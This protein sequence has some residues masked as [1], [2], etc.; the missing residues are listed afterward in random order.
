MKKSMSIAAMILLCAMILPCFAVLPTFGNEDGV[1]LIGKG[2]SVS[3]STAVPGR[4][5]SCAY[6]LKTDRVRIKGSLSTSAV[7]D[8]A[9]CTIAIFALGPGDKIADIEKG[10][11]IPTVSGIPMTT[12][13]SVDIKPDT[14]E[15][16]A[17]RCARYVIALETKGGIYIRVSEPTV[18]IAETGKLSCGFKG[19]ESVRLASALRAEA[20][21]VIVEVN[22]DRVISGGSGGYL[23]TVFGKTVRISK[24][25]IA[26]IDNQVKILTGAG[27]DVLVR[28][29][30]RG[31]VKPYSANAVTDADGS[32]SAY[33]CASFI[34]SRYSGGEYGRISGFIV[35]KSVNDIVDVNDIGDLT[36]DKYAEAYY[37]Y[38]RAVASAINDI[39]TGCSLTVPVSSDWT[40]NDGGICAEDFL[41]AIAELAHIYGSPDFGVMIESDR[42]PC[43]MNNDITEKIDGVNGNGS[44]GGSL[45]SDTAD[46]GENSDPDP[47]AKDSSKEGVTDFPEVPSVKPADEK[48]GYISSENL[49]VATASVISLS[50]KYGHVSESLIYLWEPDRETSGNALS[51]S[52]V[53]NFYRLYAQKENVSAFIVSFSD[54]ENAGETYAANEII[55]RLRYI[56]VKDAEAYVRADDILEYFGL[57][58]W[59][60]VISDEDRQRLASRVI[61]GGE[62]L[63]TAPAGIKGTYVYF[64]FRSTVGL[65]GWYAGTG[66]NSIALDRD[67]YGRALVAGFNGVGEAQG[68]YCF[69]AYGYKYEESFR[70]TDYIAVE[71]SVGDPGSDVKEYEILLKIGGKGFTNEYMGGGFVAGKKYT[72]YLDVSSMTSENIAQY[73]RIGAKGIAGE[74]HDYSVNVYSVKALSTK[75]SNSELSDKIAEERERIMSD[76]DT[77][78]G[79]DPRAVVLTVAILVLTAAVI[80]LTTVQGR[81]KKDKENN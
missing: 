16:F 23:Y 38:I 66:C 37:E 4:I 1:G 5:S 30:R 24:E 56:D 18:P 81:K 33:V 75:Y 12:L 3:A 52:Y 57:F 59:R 42:N 17:A 31:K 19:I 43:G 55:H 22:T 34:A 60:E 39:G 61:G 71:F 72:V 44:E 58:D 79:I 40:I 64:D 63:R 46:T 41:T 78:G 27:S 45:P 8:H 51:A 6:D 32:F 11:L 70:Y 14:A 69:A 15:L 9:D 25:Y 68:E 20:G 62:F 28:L 10:K 67:E 48:S 21:T 35:G 26:E 50:R 7:R 29:V 13:I 77:D 2:F 53:Y 74:E 36:E 54:K 65:N 49:S 47:G 80:V 73:L 76:D